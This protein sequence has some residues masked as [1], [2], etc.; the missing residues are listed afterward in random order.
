MRYIQT[1]SVLI[2]R[3]NVYRIVFFFLNFVELQFYPYFLFFKKKD[4]LIRLGVFLTFFKTI[5]N[6]L[7]PLF[8]TT[9]IYIYIYIYITMGPKDLGALTHFISSPR[10]I[11]R[12]KK[13]LRT[14][15]GN[16]DCQ[17]ILSRT[18]LSSADQNHRKGK[19]HAIRGSPLEH[20]KGS[21]EPNGP[22][23]GA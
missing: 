4:Y 15:K 18:T 23:K 13:C 8:Y 12:R 16:P 21:S 1:E 6:F 17:D 20:P 9:L 19:R 2:F 5:T 22:A 14:N 11:P 3:K 10:L 7:N